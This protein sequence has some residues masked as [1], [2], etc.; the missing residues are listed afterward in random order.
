MEAIS[1]LRQIGTMQIDNGNYQQALKTWNATMEH[2]LADHNALYNISV[3]FF[4]LG[5]FAEAETYLMQALKLDGENAV[6]N[7][8]MAEVLFSQDKNDKAVEYWQKALDIDPSWDIVFNNLAWMYCSEK[9]AKYY[10]PV[11]AVELAQKACDLTSY[12][13]LGHIDTLCTAYAAAGMYSEAIAAAQKALEKAESAGQSDTAEGF[14][15]RI[16][17]Y[18]N[19]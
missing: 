5:E 17:D 14:K 13:N 3:S 10:Q 19:R 7:N 18:K 8:K 12:G 4:G 1:S 2:R 6:Y 15:A 9:E 16:K 11:K